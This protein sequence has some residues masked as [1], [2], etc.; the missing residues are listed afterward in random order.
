MSRLRMFGDDE[1]ETTENASPRRTIVGGRPPEAAGPAPAVPTGLQR[2]LRLA[3][4]DEEFRAQLIERRDEVA[5][6]AGVELTDTERAILRVTPAAQIV[7]MAQHMPPPEAP[8]REFLRQT[9]ATA[10]V[11]LGGAALAACESCGPFLLT[12]G[13][14]ADMPRPVLPPPPDGGMWAQPPP[15]EPPPPRPDVNL[16]PTE[17]G[18]APDEPPPRPDVNQMQTTGGIAPDLPPPP[19]QPPVAGVRP[20]VPPEP[21]PPPPYVSPPGGARP[22]LPPESRPDTTRPSRGIAPDVPPKK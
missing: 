8:R 12:R 22:D 3:A 9:A 18:A 7:A 1:P 17:G 14:T 2:L 10:V 4:L 20:D 15:P 13:A 6:A 21:Q 16:M 19:P 11:L 5:S